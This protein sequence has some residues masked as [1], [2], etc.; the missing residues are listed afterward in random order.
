MNENMDS[1]ARASLPASNGSADYWIVEMAMSECDKA[2][3]SEKSALEYQ[4]ITSHAL[5]KPPIAVK[6][7]S[8]QGMRLTRIETIG[9]KQVQCFIEDK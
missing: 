1:T 5:N 9:G 3:R 6:K 4:A 8:H 2:F 7:V